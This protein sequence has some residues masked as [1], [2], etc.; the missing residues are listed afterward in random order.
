LIAA[1]RHETLHQL[2]LVVGENDVSGRHI[3]YIP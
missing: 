3:R 2:G 1:G